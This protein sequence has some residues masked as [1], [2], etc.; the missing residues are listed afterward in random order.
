MTSTPPAV[1]IPTSG[2]SS[3]HGG[4]MTPST[5]SPLSYSMALANAYATANVRLTHGEVAEL[6]E[7]FRV[8]AGNNVVQQIGIQELKDVLV[9]V[10]IP[11]MDDMG[12]LFKVSNQQSVADHLTFPEFVLLM[13]KEVDEKMQ[14]ELK[15]AFRQYDKTGTGCVSTAQFCEMLATMG[16]KSSPEEVHDMMLFADPEG[17]G[18]IDYAKIIQKLADKLKR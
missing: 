9:S 16:D 18:K 6:H 12:D 14:E 11:S 7:G 1:S 4:P 8:L 2:K 13:T 10:G 3:H 5:A 15:L 17:T